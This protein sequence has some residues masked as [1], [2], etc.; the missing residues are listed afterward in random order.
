MMSRSRSARTQKDDGSRRRCV[1]RPPAAAKGGS[2]VRSRRGSGKSSGR[3][4]KS[5][6]RSGSR[7]GR[8][9]KRRGASK[10]RKGSK[11]RKGRKSRKRGQTAKVIINVAVQP[12]M[13]KKQPMMKKKK[14]C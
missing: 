1:G 6:K 12:M 14:R 4:L 9:G 11:D 7:M 10:R 8:K 13:K 5:R 2:T 3:K